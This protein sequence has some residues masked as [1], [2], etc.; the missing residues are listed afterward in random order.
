MKTLNKKKIKII[1][2]LPHQDCDTNMMYSNCPGGDP[3]PSKHQLNKLMNLQ[4]TNSA[5]TLAVPRETLLVELLYYFYKHLNNNFDSVL[6]LI[7]IF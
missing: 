1:I 3:R 4:P 5:M 2:F 7:N 6:F